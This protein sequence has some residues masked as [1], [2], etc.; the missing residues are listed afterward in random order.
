MV[1]RLAY[2]ILCQIVTCHVIS[3]DIIY[4]FFKYL[5]NDTARKSLACQ[6]NVLERK[7]FSSS[8]FSVLDL[9]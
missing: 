6:M 3:F 5:S 8:K 1:Q 7:D 4:T 9:H 2:N